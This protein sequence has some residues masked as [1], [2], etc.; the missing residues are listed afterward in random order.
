MFFAGAAFTAGAGNEL[1]SVDSSSTGS[2]AVVD[3][4]PTADATSADT[5]GADTSS[6]AATGADTTSPAATGA[7]TTSPDTTSPDTTTPDTA[8]PDTA[9]PDTTGTDTSSAGSTSAD[10]TTAGDPIAPA[11]SAP[12]VSTPAVSTPAVSTPAASAPAAAAPA[13]DPASDSIALHPSAPASSTAPVSSTPV[14]TV[15]PKHRAALRR[16]AHRV[17]ANVSAAARIAI[18]YQALAFDPQAWLRNNAASAMGASAVSIAEHYLGV[19]YVWGG[20]APASGFD[21][22]GLTQFVYAQLGVTLPHYA[23]AQFAAFPKL[24]PTQLAPGDLVFFEP[25]F[26]GPG[27][28]ALYI[29]NDQIV[30]APHTG[31]LV[32]VSSFSGAAAQMGLIGAVRPYADVV[33]PEPVLVASLMRFS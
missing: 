22:S 23:A 1:A 16:R 15:A 8:S 24:D 25:K 2:A 9:S 18:P 28:V 31:A 21:C 10:P 13:A 27:H 19:P 4:A 26:D 30:E 14:Q 3:A 33:A 6:A 29:G 5:S 12:A 20:A 32:R 11:V 7:D 17:I